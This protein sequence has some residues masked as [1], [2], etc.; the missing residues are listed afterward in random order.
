MGSLI[1]LDVDG[2]LRPFIERTM[3]V[4]EIDHKVTLEPFTNKKN[5]FDYFP[6]SKEYT[7]NFIFNTRVKEIFLDVDP[8]P[9]AIEE[10]NFLKK[11]CD[12]T[13]IT[14][15][16]V[17]SQYTYQ[18]KILT[19]MWLHKH[20]MLTENLAFCTYKNK[21]II[22]GTMLIDD[23]PDNLKV[24]E[25]NNKLAICYHRNWNTSWKGTTIKSLKQIPNL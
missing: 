2:V 14:L 17:T 12:K 5:F 1:C 18:T 4:Y 8:Y 23:E 20:H 11:Y 22:N 9:E 13:N 25:E 7:R 19:I 3:E 10:F 16:L 6:T 24:W 15:M 21:H